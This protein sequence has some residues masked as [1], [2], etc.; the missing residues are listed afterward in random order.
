MSCMGH[1]FKVP[2]HERYLQIILKFAKCKPPCEVYLFEGV[3]GSGR[4]TSWGGSSPFSCETNCD[5]SQ[6]V[7]NIVLRLS[8]E[9]FACNCVAYY[10][11]HDYRE[12]S[13][14]NRVRCKCPS[15]RKFYDREGMWDEVSASKVVSQPWVP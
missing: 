12:V 2:I 4:V 14:D 9:S 6:K 3:K 8:C 5:F 1:D 13:C 15:C 11:F 7:T 10:K